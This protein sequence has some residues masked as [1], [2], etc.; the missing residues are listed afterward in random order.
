MMMKRTAVMQAAKSFLLFLIVIATNTFSAGRVQAQTCN[1]TFS[2][3]ID[4]P[5]SQTPPYLVKNQPILTVNATITVNNGQA[6][7]L[8]GT[9]SLKDLDTGE[10]YDA[11]GVG[12]S[13][14]TSTI[15]IPPLELDT[16]RWCFKRPLNLQVIGSWL[17]SSYINGMCEQITPQCTGGASNSVAVTICNDHLC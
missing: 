7:N 12:A 13:G 4:A 1:L 17:Y 14:P 9:V 6:C 16:T 3:T 5:P 8:A 15:T 2:I 11:T 10:T